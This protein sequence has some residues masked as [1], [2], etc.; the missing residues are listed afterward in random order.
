MRVISDD[1]GFI[2]L[3]CPACGSQRTLTRFR[4]R[5]L[6]GRERVEPEQGQWLPCP[7]C[8]EWSPVEGPDVATAVR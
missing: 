8:Q 6:N 7:V 2:R 1:G 3:A 5:Q 4:S